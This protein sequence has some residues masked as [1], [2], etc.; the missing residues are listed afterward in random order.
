MNAIEH[1]EADGL[2]LPDDKQDEEWG[3]LADWQC[4]IDDILA[5]MSEDEIGTGG[6]TKRHY[7]RANEALRQSEVDMADGEAF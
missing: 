2:I 6:V 3:T 7:R 5:G 4:L 1:L